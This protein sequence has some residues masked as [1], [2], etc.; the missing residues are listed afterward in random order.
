MKKFMTYLLAVVMFLSVLAAPSMQA[1]AAS[2]RVKDLYEKKDYNLTLLGQNYLYVCGKK[3]NMTN[4]PIFMRNGAYM[5]S[6][7]KIFKNTDLQVGVVD[8]KENG[9]GVIKITYGSKTLI[10][11]EGTRTATLNGAE[12]TLSAVPFR[13]YYYNCSAS[14]WVVPI[15]SV[16]SKLGISYTRTSDGVIKIGAAKTTTTA[17]KKIVLCIDAGHG[18]YDSGAVGNNL[19]EKDLTLKIVLEAK[20]YFDT[21]SRFQVYYTRINDTY[22]SLI[23]RSDLANAKKADLF[24]CI[25]INYFNASSRGTETMYNPARLSATKKNNITSYQ[26]ANAMQTA[27]VNATGFPNRGLVERT[28]LSVL[29]HT[30]MPACLIEYGF[31]S[32]KTEATSMKNNTAKYGKA[33]YNATVTFCKNKGLY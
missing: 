14:R 27:T 8:T 2:I 21:N 1:S 19:K 23:A 16:C 17:P 24:L 32:N 5:G 22:P 10:I 26:L 12:T 9:V 4:I 20:K 28:G 30:N 33:L 11:R 18:G 7:A 6:L 29:N 31:I 13:A 25:H 15:W 3:I